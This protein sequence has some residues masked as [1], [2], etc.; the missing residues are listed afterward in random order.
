MAQEV[1]KLFDASENVIATTLS[2]ENGYYYFLD[3]GI[4]TFIVKAKNNRI[5]QSIEVKKKKEERKKEKKRGKRRGSDKNK[6]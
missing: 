2:D 6:K 1:V 3:V 4:G 5:I